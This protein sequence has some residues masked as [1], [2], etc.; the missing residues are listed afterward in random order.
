MSEP[1]EK[2]ENYG[3]IPFRQF[4]FHQLFDVARMTTTPKITE[5]YFLFRQLHKVHEF[6]I[7][8]LH[9]VAECL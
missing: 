7:R 2:S 9:S 8:Q 6:S 3:W 5:P 4:P 1:K